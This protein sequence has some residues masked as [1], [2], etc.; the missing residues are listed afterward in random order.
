MARYNRVKINDT[1]LTTTG[2]AG[3]TLC[4]VR[5]LNLIMMR[6]APRNVEPDLDGGQH[7]QFG[8]FRDF[9]IPMTVESKSKTDLDALIAEINEV[10]ED[11]SFHNIVIEGDTGNF[12]VDCALVKIGNE[13]TF[14][15]GV[16]NRIELVFKVDTMNEYVA[17]GP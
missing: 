8:D 9:E 15:N 16:I 7:V 6:I 17:P 1:Y 11:G 13:G 3:G 4:R 12:D 14:S 5:I 2:L 10:E